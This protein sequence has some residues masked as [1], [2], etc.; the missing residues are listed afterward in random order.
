LLE[1]RTD[2]HKDGV[3]GVKNLEIAIGNIMRIAAEIKRGKR[4]YLK[5]HEISPFADILFTY[6]Q[7]DGTHHIFERYPNPQEVVQAY[8]TV[9][10]Y[11]ETHIRRSRRQ[12]TSH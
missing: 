5:N 1:H 7:L 2:T 11:Y 4:Q 12:K 8:L 10:K 9:R 6:L 3:M